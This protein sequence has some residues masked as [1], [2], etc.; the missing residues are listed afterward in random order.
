[1]TSLSAALPTLSFFSVRYKTE[2]F[3]GPESATS[4]HYMERDGNRKVQ[5]PLTPITLIPSRNRRHRRPAFRFYL[6]AHAGV[7]VGPVR[8]TEQT[9]GTNLKRVDRTR[10]ETGHSDRRFQAG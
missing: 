8:V 2:L 7:R 4:L 3:R 5:P 9:Q 6:Y 10:R 1:M